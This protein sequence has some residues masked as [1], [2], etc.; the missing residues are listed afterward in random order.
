FLGKLLTVPEMVESNAERDRL[1]RKTGAA[2][3]AMETEVIAEACAKHQ[4]PILSLRAVSDTSSEPFPAPSH[5]LFDLAKQKTDFIRLASYLLTHPGAL[6]RLAAFR[7]RI[8]VAR[9]AL[10]GALDTIVR[11]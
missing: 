6:S 11:P 7:E 5:V 10:A 4:L 2:A 1:A 9:K 8:M 3:V